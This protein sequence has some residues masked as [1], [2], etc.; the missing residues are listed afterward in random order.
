MEGSMTRS[1]LL[2]SVTALL[3]PACQASEKPGD[4]IDGG[5][6]AAATNVAMDEQAIRGQVDGLNS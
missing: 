2:L 3:L 6:A 1:L 4:N 5:N